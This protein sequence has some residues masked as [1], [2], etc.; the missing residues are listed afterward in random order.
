M[1]VKKTNT[2]APIEEPV[3][4]KHRG[5]AKSGKKDAT[6]TYHAEAGKKVYV[7][8]EF[9]GW[10]PTDK[11]MAFKP[12]KG[13]YTVT[14]K[15]LPGTYQYKFVVDGVWAADPENVNSVA[16]DQGTFNSVIEVK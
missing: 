4:K 11:E 7:A 15:L 5:R 10:D 6:F 16:N 3:V 8:G 2:E 12:R 9:N 1:R 13:I 14:L